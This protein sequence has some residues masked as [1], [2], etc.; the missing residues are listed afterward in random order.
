MEPRRDGA[1]ENTSREMI[2]CPHQPG[3]LRLSIQACAMRYREAQRQKPSFTSDE[4]GM[5]R[6]AGLEICKVCKLG[7]D[8]F[9]HLKKKGAF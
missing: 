3:K 8:H 2:E 6:R 1:Q 7:R 4:F 9:E 5:A